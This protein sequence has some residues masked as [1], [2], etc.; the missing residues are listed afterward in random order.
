MTG[1]RAV[2]VRGAIQSVATVAVVGG[3]IGWIAGWQ[4]GHALV[5]AG[6]A[7]FLATLLRGQMRRS[8]Y[9]GVAY[10]PGTAAVKSLQEER[11]EDAVAERAEQAGYLRKLAFAEPSETHH[12]PPALMAQW[13]ALTSLDRHSDALVVAEEVVAVGRIVDAVRNEGRPVV[14][15]ALELLE[16]SLSE[17][18]PVRVGA[19][20]DELLM[21]R[22][23]RARSAN[24]QHAQALGIVADRHLALNEYDAARPL[25]EERTRV[26]RHLAADERLVN[27]LTALGHCL[28]ELGEHEAARTAHAEALEIAQSI[29]LDDAFAIGANLA[30]SLRELQRYDEAVSLSRSVVTTLRADHFSE[31]RHETSAARLTW[32]LDLLGDD[33]RALHRLDEA[34]EAYEEALTVQRSTGQ[35]EDA[36]PPV[37]RTLR[38]LGRAD[39][40]HALEEELSALRKPSGR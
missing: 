18:P 19:E 13:R 36:L 38:A 1:E 40:A 11:F 10:V 7:G 25:L 21:M 23:E 8:W 15:L 5:T 30:A 28:T 26:R 20:A 16:F 14:D 27:A 6:L 22:A 37:I 35:P 34:L 29:D 33:L 39:E 2:Y 9:L 17:L 24:R 12:L 32:A 4:Y 3:V 31:D